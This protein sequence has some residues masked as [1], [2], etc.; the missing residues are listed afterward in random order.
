MTEASH[1]GEKRY[2]LDDYMDFENNLS[3][4]KAKSVVAAKVVEEEVSFEKKVVSETETQSVIKEECIPF[5]SS[6]AEGLKS[7]V[8]GR[9]L[10]RKEF[11]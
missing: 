3:Q 5:N 11:N 4:A 9:R 10:Q 6:I 7:R 1:E 2:S 8:A